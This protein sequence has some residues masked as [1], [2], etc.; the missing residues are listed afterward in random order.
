MNK[1]ASFSL[2]KLV[3]PDSSEKCCFSDFQ[4]NLLSPSQVEL[5]RLSTLSCL[6]DQHSYTHIL[7]FTVFVSVDCD[8]Y[9]FALKKICVTQLS[10]FLRTLKQN[11][12]S[13]NY[14][15]AVETVS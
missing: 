6:D 4:I 14:N 2:G 11:T 5:Y 8:Y 13:I 15:L 7:L 9:Y 1:F 12:I 10:E 3:A